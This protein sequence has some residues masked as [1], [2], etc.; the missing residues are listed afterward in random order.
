MI[1]KNLMKKIDSIISGYDY[2]AHKTFYHG[3]IN[4]KIPGNYKPNYSCISN[5]NILGFLFTQLNEEEKEE[6]KNFDI[7]DLNKILYNKEKYRMYGIQI[8]EQIERNKIKRK[9]R[10]SI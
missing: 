8:S 6:I 10:W 4:S 5:D 3:G 1:S 2:Q 9:G 7:N